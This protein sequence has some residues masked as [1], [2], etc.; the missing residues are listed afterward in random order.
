MRHNGLVL[1]AGDVWKFTRFRLAQ[2]LEGLN[3][4]QLRFRMHESA[5]SIYEI[6][7]HIAGAEHYWAVRFD[8]RDSDASELDRKLSLAIFDGFLADGSAPFAGDDLSLENLNFVLDYTFGEIAPIFEQD[9]PEHL[10]MNLVSPI[11]DTITGEEGLV[12]LA[13]HAAY[14]TG[15]IWMIR[16][17]PDFPA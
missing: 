4:S 1:D 5:H 3:D 2:S 13:Q 9:R 14:H 16:M 8:Q 11:G 12:R 6:G 17:H 15:Q 7:F 10:A